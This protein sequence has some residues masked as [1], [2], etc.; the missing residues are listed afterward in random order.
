MVSKNP[1]L[2]NAR[3]K[4]ALESRN[5]RKIIEE[6]NPQNWYDWILLTTS[7]KTLAEERSLKLEN[8]WSQATGNKDLSINLSLSKE[9]GNV[10]LCDGIYLLHDTIRGLADYTILLDVPVSFCIENTLI[11]DAHRSSKS[12]LEYKVSL[13]YKYDKPYFEEFQNQVDTIVSMP[14]QQLTKTTS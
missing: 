8:A 14:H 3:I 11:R 7:L 6:E 4:T 12:Y 5:A 1:T 9:K 13:L 10:I 2:R